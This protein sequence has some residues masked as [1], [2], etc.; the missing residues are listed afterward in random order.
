MGLWP[1]ARGASL[2][3][4]HLDLGRRRQQLLPRPDV[5]L[6]DGKPVRS[7]DS[8]THWNAKLTAQLVPANALTLAYFRHVRLVDGRGAG[9]QRSEPST[10]DV[11]FPGKSYKVEDSQVLSEKLFAALHFSYVP[12]YREAV[13]KGGLDQQADADADY[14]WR[15]SFIYEFDSRTLHQAGLTASAFFGTDPLRHELKFG[16]GYR[17]ARVIL[18]RLAGGPAR[19]PRLPRPRASGGDP[20]NERERPRQLLQHLPLRYDSDGQ[21]H[22]QPRGALRLPAVPKPSLRGLSQS[23][24]SGAPARRAVRR[25]L[26]IP[27]H[28]ALSAAPNRRHLRDW[29]DRQTLLRASFARFSDQLGEEI[30]HINAFPGIAELNYRW[31]DANQ[32]GR[33]EPPEV[34]T[35]S[36]RIVEREPGRPGLRR[37]RQSDRGEPGATRDGRVHRRRRT[38]ALHRPLRL[39]RLHLP[40]IERPAVFT[41]DRHDARELPV[42]GNAT[43]TISDPTTGFVLDFSEPY[44]GLTT[45]P[46]PNGSVLQNRPDTT[47]IY[48]GLELQLMKSFSNGWMLRVGFAYNNWRQ[49]VAP[50]ESSTRTTRFPGTN[51]SGPIVEENINATWQFNVSGTGSFRSRSRRASTSSAGRDFRSS[52]PSSSKPTTRA[53]PPAVFRSDPRRPIEPRTSTSSTFSSRATSLSDR[54]SRSRPSSPASTCWT[55]TPCSPATAMSATST[56]RRRRL[57][58]RI[59]FIQCSRRDSR[60]TGRFAEGVRISF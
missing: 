23:C 39:A 21:S 10:F 22:D 16:F 52:I 41:A 50:A 56:R 20:R 44:Y 55:A 7:Q 11:T 53:Q 17:H 26:R 42:R 48:D 29:Q 47:E 8:N 38:A 46:A 15:N 35:R 59:R 60:A 31:D 3:G 2:E 45:D 13:P 4:P 57:S 58:I 40:A 36:S 33:V 34:D 54:E 27:A 51:A 43:G 19:G 18:F 28:V 1:R 49:Q 30:F 25:G 24:V 6:P 37:S 12:G 9:P 32:N 14:V 5:F